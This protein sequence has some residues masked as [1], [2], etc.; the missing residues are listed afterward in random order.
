MKIILFISIVAGILIGI[1]APYA[2][3]LTPVTGNALSNLILGLTNVALANGGAT[4]TADTFITGYPPAQAINGIIDSTPYPWNGSS[5]STPN[6]WIPVD[7]NIS[8]ISP[9]WLVVDF[10]QMVT[11]GVIVISGRYP[12]R[13]AGT[14][15]LQYTRDPSPVTQA[16]SWTTIGTY[17]WS[18]ANPLPRTGFQF[19][20]AADITGVQ[21]LS[22]PNYTYNN[23]YSGG[24]WG[25]SIQ[26][27]EAYESAGPPPQIPLNYLTG[28]GL[29]NSV[30]SFILHGV[31]G[32]NYVSEVSSDLMYWTPFLTNTIPPGGWVLIT[33]P[34]AE[35]QPQEFY[36]AL[37][38]VTLIT[39]LPPAPAGLS[40]AAQTSQVFLSWNPAP[41]AITYNV[42]RATVS[43]GPYA[44][45][46]SGITAT[47]YTDSGVTNGTTYYYVVSAVNS[48]GEG[49]NSSEVSATPTTAPPA[50]AGV[51]YT[52]LVFDDEFN[53]INT[54]DAD[55]T[56][57]PG[58][59]WYV[60][61]P[62]GGGTVPP[63]AYTVSNGVLEI[64]FGDQSAS[65]GL[66]TWNCA[67][68]T[69]HAFRYGY[70]E[71]R[72]HFNPT[73][74]TNAPTWPAFWTFPTDHTCSGVN[75]WN[76]LDVFEAYTGGDAA[77]SG[78]F[79]GTVHDW[80][81]NG[82]YIN[83]QNANNYQPTSVN[84]NQ[85]HT[86]GCLWLPGQISWYLDNNLL[87]TQSY[88]D[89]GMPIPCVNCTSGSGC[90]TGLFSVMD[91]ENN[92]LILGSSQE[93]PMYVDWVHVWQQ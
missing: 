57:A 43:G 72:V 38:L 18:S 33:D 81:Y 16:S 48:F 9:D 82:S 31:P 44:S 20:P 76:E 91:G 13:G 88:S 26:Q 50:A 64:A 8:G 35:S 68:G 47:N 86:L 77:Y 27:L 74:G 73:L 42:K 1:D 67:G 89:T 87:M 63:S 55:N 4:D 14:Y 62:F 61:L 93:W 84:W 30:F 40:A 17:T 60:Q 80:T 21:L 65:W 19:G 24:G 3:T 12:E 5:D 25:N 10:H 78:A 28:P 22:A 92:M 32:T 85:W 11:L 49:A 75:H 66:S 15:T 71:A 53:S 29:S 70:F 51:D 36:W 34:F 46:V 90:A 54:I 7:V 83:C 2:Q 58:Y 59:N 6:P 37:P 23:G 52:N 41:R 39:V 56:G 45:G 79:V 69:G